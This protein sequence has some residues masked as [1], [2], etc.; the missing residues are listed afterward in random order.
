M[1]AMMTINGAKLCGL[2]GKGTL[3]VGADA[4]VTVID[5]RESWKIDVKEFASKSRNCPFDGWSVTG[6]AI[7][8]IVAGR[9]KMNREGARLR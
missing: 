9:V 3:A 1:I 8:T 2:A 6:R 7:T 4:D 5:P